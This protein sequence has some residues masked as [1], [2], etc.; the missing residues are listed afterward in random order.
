M[1]PILRRVLA[2]FVGTVAA[3]V[4]V[5]LSD[6]LVARMYPW[7]AGTDMRNAESFAAAIEAVPLP[8]LLLMV[9]GW[10]VAA[11]I[12]AFVAVRLSVERTT[13]VGFVVAGLLLLATVANLAMLPHPRWMWIAPLLVVPLLGWLG[14]RAGAAP[15][16]GSRPG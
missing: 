16:S 12:G 6:A 2:G 15:A 11:G 14:A 7:P 13:T 8:G 1:S 9:I 5:S 4:V 10:G 3:L